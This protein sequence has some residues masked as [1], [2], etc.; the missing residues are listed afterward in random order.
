MHTVTIPANALPRAR[1]YAR[2]V[3]ENGHVP[4]VLSGAELRGNASKYGSRYGKMRGRVAAAL[5]PFGIVDGYHGRARVWLD[6]L[7][8]SPVRISIA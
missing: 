6:A 2:H 7:T 8:A 1:Y 4:G 5:K 3:A